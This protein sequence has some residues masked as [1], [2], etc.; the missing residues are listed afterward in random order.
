M[1]EVLDEPLRAVVAARGD[2][3]DALTMTRLFEKAPGF[4]TVLNGPEHLFTFANAAYRNLFGDRGYVG[5]T[6]REAF[7]E[8]EGQGFY[9]LLD[10]VYATGERFV[11]HHIPVRIEAPGSGPQERF[12]DFI[13]EPVME[14]AGC[15]T[16]IFV[17]GYDV[18]RRVVAEAERGESEARLRALNAELEAKVT[19]RARERSRT[20]LVSPDLLGVANADGFFHSTNPAWAETLG[21]SQEEIARTPFMELVHPDDHAK[22][23]SGFEALIRGD[24]LLRFENRYRH[25]KGG[26]RWISWVAV[27]EGEEFYCSGRDVTVE[28]AQ[29]AE[30]ADRT[31]E[32][33]GAWRLSQDLLAVN[34]TDGTLLSTNAAWGSLLGWTAEDLIGR[35]LAEFTHPDDLEGTKAAFAEIVHSPVTTPHEYRLRHRDGSWRCFA[36][37][38]AF[39]SGRVYAVG[40]DTTAERANAVSLALAEEAL[41]QSQK[42][43]AVGQLTGGVAHDFNNLLTVIR[44]SVELLRRPN[45]SEERRTRYIDAISDTATRATRLTSQLLAFARRQALQP[46]VFDTVAS[47]GAVTSM[48]QSLTGPR[49][50]VEARVVDGACWVDADPSQFDTA[51]VN[52]AVNARDAMS[53]EGR[54]TIEVRPASAIP[55]VR[56]HPPV[57]GPFV[58]VSLSDTGSGMPPETIERIF[59]PFFTTKAVGHGTGLGLS[60]V[61]GFAKQSGGEVDVSSEVGRGTTFTLY[62]P[63]VAPPASANQIVDPLDVL[64]DG[65]GA[66]VL[67]VEDNEDVGAF[68]TQALAELGY[69]TV[70]AVDAEAALIELERDAG[71]FDVVFSDVVMPGMNGVEL[72]QEIRRRHQAL[73]VL[74]TSGYSHVLAQNGT[75]GF[76]LLHKP[77][78]I[79]QLSRV[80]R[81]AA[82]WRQRQ[83]PPAD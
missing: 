59:E 36:W 68:A 33:D 3:T 62:L 75:H 82:G 73:P 58:A 79:E 74:L 34:S 12:L 10:R 28:K 23:V 77:Y 61:F 27:P 32:R 17:E 42:M 24:P 71:R 18:T 22:S 40:R 55:T 43:E 49:V 47:L 20:W 21:W 29:A 78:S 51:L 65:Q 39:E 4:I 46:E 30:L 83:S 6:V 64:V 63:R 2:E 66:C 7:P 52:M 13:Y 14:E 1:A 44:G 67:V 31:A 69:E 9:E 25:K 53:G 76:E 80:L 38:A 11:A 8:L 48:V 5:R 15:V 41:R 72:G 19:E 57:D 56:G 60:Q 35:S 45:L 37:T 54:L 70:L 81:K 16:G 50:Q 26:Y